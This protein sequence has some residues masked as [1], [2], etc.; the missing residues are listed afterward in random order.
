VEKAFY[1]NDLREVHPEINKDYLENGKI[2]S[3]E[4]KPFG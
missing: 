4:A 1:R 2:P 3:W